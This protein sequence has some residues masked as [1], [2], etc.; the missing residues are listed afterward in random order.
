MSEVTL[1]PEPSLG[2][3][4]AAWR[5]HHT[6]RTTFSLVLWAFGLYAALFAHPPVIITPAKQQA[7]AVHI[8][9]AEVHAPARLAAL[10]A[11]HDA[12][13]AVYDAR[14]WTWR[15]DTRQRAVVHAAREVER[16]RLRAFQAADAEHERHL[17][18]A[19]REL[20]LFSEYGV[21]EA[22]HKFWEEYKAGKVFARQQTV[23]DVF[24]YVLSGGREDESMVQFVAQ[25]LLRV[26][27]NLTVGL[28]MAVFAF[29]CRLPAL[30][31][32]FAPPPL[33]ALLFFLVASLGA[34]AVVTG[35]LGL[36]YGAAGGAVYVVARASHQARL[37]A[38]RQAGLEGRA[39]AD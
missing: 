16:K 27:L 32:A 36:M 7:A 11:L 33:E 24:A 23:Y 17:R 2:R 25:W 22:R 9:A 20:G 3:A 34:V 12:R 39:H 6:P 10:A 30:I 19:R 1:R 15:F 38:Q 21:G 28:V 5:P 37:E 31:W 18:R 13:H 26:C 29:L 35:T 14:T 4:L 8:A